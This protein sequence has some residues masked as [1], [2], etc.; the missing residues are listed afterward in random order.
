MRWLWAENKVGGKRIYILLQLAL[1]N[2]TVTK[3]AA[4][5]GLDLLS[6]NL[7]L[8]QLSD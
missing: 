4:P 2:R 7:L 1:Y 6:F 5:R 3:M 8:A